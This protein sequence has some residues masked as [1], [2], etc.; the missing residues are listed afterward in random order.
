MK[1]SRLKD[2]NNNKQTGHIHKMGNGC[3]KTKQMRKKKE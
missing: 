2:N 3:C 1:S